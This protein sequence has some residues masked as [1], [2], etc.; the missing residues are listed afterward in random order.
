MANILIVD[1]YYSTAL[2]Y[3]EILKELGHRAFAVSGGEKALYYALQERIDVLIVDERLTDVAPKELLRNLKRRQ[4]GIR[5]ILCGWRD[6]YSPVHAELWDEVIVK[7]CDFSMLQAKV[8][9]L[10]ENPGPS[11]TTLPEQEAGLTPRYSGSSEA[12]GY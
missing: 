3:R 11:T 12:G 10:A 5:A 6:V 7:S 4:P 1:H 2:L 9:T 8:K